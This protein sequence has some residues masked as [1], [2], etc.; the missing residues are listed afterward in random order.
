MSGFSDAEASFVIAITERSYLNIGWGVSA[1]FKIELHSKDLPLLN[2]IT[3]FFK[4]VGNINEHKTRNS[5]AYTV[6]SVKDLNNII[7][8]HLCGARSD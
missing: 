3:S 7:I 2:Q 5:V 6:N 8:P 4:D 1:I